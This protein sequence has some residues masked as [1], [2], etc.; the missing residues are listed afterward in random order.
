[1]LGC[2]AKSQ[3]CSRTVCKAFLY[4]AFCAAGA[5]L[6]SAALDLDPHSGFMVT[7]PKL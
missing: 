7:L 2:L 3:F 4:Q 6:P 1:M 5:Q